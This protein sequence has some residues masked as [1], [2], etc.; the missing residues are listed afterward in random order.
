[1]PNRRGHS[2]FTLVELLVVIAIIGILMAILL[3]AV[4]YARETSRKAGCAN[5][6]KQIGLAAH[7]FHDAY[8]RLPP[9]Y[10]GPIP[11]ADWNSHQT[12]NQ[13][14]GV[15]AYLL[16]YLEQQTVADQ[17]KTNLDLKVVGPAWWTDAP[18]TATACTRLEVFLCPSTDAYAQLDGI[19]L[20]RNVF[21]SPP[22]L[23]YQGQSSSSTS[24]SLQNVGR[25][26]YLGSAGYMGNVP[27]SSNAVT[28]IG[29]FGN[30]TTFRLD[31]IRDG[32]SNVLLFGESTG[33]YEGNRRQQGPTWIG[34]GIMVTA[35]G[36][37]T[38]EWYAFNSDH[39]RIV[40]FGL[41]DGSVRKLATT[42]D[43]GSFNCLGGIR[44]GILLS[45]TALPW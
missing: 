14:V 31:D 42:I 5:N 7:S 28:Y 23:V 18:T 33:G 15:L 27:N 29:A 36:L 8:K 9:G 11:H 45:T 6:L 10:L 32:M 25:S 26:N 17:I 43:D 20:T 41:A 37:H 44:D 2:A 19:S 22:N 40:H 13:Y 39:A 30:R 24:P 3:P 34:A 35:W 16:P 38:K 12:D 1:M 21:L 4:Q